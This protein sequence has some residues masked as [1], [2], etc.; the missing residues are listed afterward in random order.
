MR[1]ETQEGETPCLNQDILPAKHSAST[2]VLLKSH[3][4]SSSLASLP[5]HTQ[6]VPPPVMC[7]TRDGC[8]GRELRMPYQ[9]PKMY[10][11]AL[12]LH[13]RRT[14]P[15]RAE[16][17][18]PCQATAPPGCLG[19]PT[20]PRA[21][22]IMNNL[23]ASPSNH[24]WSLKLLQQPLARAPPVNQLTSRNP[25]QYSG[26]PPA[27]CLRIDTHHYMQCDLPSTWVAASCSCAARVKHN[28]NNPTQPAQPCTIHL[29]V[30]VNQPA[31]TA[32]S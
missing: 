4:P 11:T 9:E 32:P 7:S 19:N 1:V 2:Q 23:H 15:S 13:A 6:R 22:P 26:L 27:A 24:S 28:P 3:P 25:T 10:R 12:G 20:M 30:E 8:Y 14:A 16:S 21:Y 31:S 29:W 17:M 5:T 18:R